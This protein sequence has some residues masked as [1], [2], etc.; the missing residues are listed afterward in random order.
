MHSYLLVFLGAALCVAVYTD[1]KEQR[2][3]N[4]LNLTIALTGLGFHTLLPLFSPTLIMPDALD[5]LRFSLAGLGVGL[6]LMLLPYL[7]G[8]M[9]GGDVKL[10][11]AIGACLGWRLTVDAFLYTS[12]AG[13]AYALAVLLFRHRGML[14]RILQNFW[15]AL[16]LLGATRKARYAPV[17]GGEALPRLCYGLAIAAGTA[18]ALLRSMNDQGLTAALF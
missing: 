15:T 17:Q 14:V 13:G 10:L 9:G 4:A 2:I 18:V 16:W 6:G 8:V 1:L 5:G 7:F 12:L 11:A 3:P